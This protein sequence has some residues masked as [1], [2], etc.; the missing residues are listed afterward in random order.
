M[1]FKHVNQSEWNDVIAYTHQ[2]R[3]EKLLQINTRLNSCYDIHGNLFR[4]IQWVTLNIPA[5]LTDQQD[6]NT[7]V[8]EVNLFS[9]Q[10]NANM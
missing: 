9:D 2:I 5:T 1:R 10:F 3:T 8:L 7:R 6:K 4:E